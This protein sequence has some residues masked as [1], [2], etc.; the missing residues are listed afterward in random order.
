MTWPP[1]PGELLP[2]A[3]EAVG[4]REKL[5]GYS[6]NSLHD[7]GG[8]KADGFRRILGITPQ[9][10]EYLETAIRAGVL[11]VPIR[12]VRD[13][14]S[15]GVNCL[16]EMPLRGTGTKSTR[17]VDLRTAWELAD[18]NAAPRL[19]TAYLKP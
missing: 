16:V 17:K 5:I 3:A 6:L 8:P 9:D 15:S 11:V 10:V 19:V 4:V 2:R 7:S 13:K 14:G 1:Q 18:A 12:S